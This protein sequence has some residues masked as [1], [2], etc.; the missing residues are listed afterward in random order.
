VIST[1]LCVEIT[2]LDDLHFQP[3]ADFGQEMLL[4]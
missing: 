2:H 3:D 1:R 4:A